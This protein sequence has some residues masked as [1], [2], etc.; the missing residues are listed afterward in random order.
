MNAPIKVLQITIGGKEYTGIASYFYQYYR[1]IDHDRVHFDFAFCRENSM[2]L[3]KDDPIF[4]DSNFIE[5]NAVG[6]DGSLNYFKLWTSLSDQLKKTNYDI[7]TI[8]THRVGVNI[9]SLLAAKRRCIKTI[10]SHSHN[11]DLKQGPFGFKAKIKGNISRIMGYY[12]RKNADYLFAC[13]E[14]AG[15]ALFGNKGVEQDNFR[16]IC[17][18]ID[19]EKYIFNQNKRIEIRKSFEIFDDRLII[20]QIGRLSPQKNQLFALAV[21]AEIL[22]VKSNAEFWIVGNGKDMDKL[23]DRAKELYIFKHIRFLGERDDV[24]KLLQ[25]MDAMIFPSRWEGLGIVAVEG[26]AAGLPIYASDAV[27][28]ETQITDLIHYIPLTQPPTYWAD[29]ILE[30]YLKHERRDMHQEIIN[31]GYDIKAAAKWL[32]DF[33]CRMRK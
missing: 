30:D 20:G 10:I 25:G 16:V 4:D 13:S 6:K 15:R 33:Y 7:V 21:F 5:L 22:K 3:I 17:N 14:N 9:V 31:H 26:Q 2:K 12:L 8:N 24:P 1:H 11:N 29:F 23:I 27:T 19:S 32:E 28:K 18:A